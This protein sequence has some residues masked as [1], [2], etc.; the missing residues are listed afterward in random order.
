MRRRRRAKILATLGPSSAS[1][2]RIG[3][4]VDAGA[5]AFRFNFS[6]GTHEQHQA[7]YDAVRAVEEARGR[8]IAVVMDVQGPKLRVGE[9]NDGSVQLRAGQRF[10]LD[11]DGEAGNQD[12]V[13]LPHPEIF[14]T[15]GAGDRLL[16]DDGKIRL[17]VK[18]VASRT[19]DTVVEAGGALSD[20]KGVNLP[21]VVLPLSPLTEKD[22]SDLAFGIDMGVDWVALSFVQR[23]EDVAEA[24][25]LTGGR[26][27]LMA[28]I[29][30]PAAIE[31]LTEIIELSDGIMIARGDLGV[32]LPP[33]DVPSLQ[34]KI[35]RAARDAGKP[36]V[37]ATQMLESMIRAPAPTRAEASDVAT[38]AYDGADAM[39]LSAE[40]AVGDY[41]VEAVAMMDRIL[42]KVERDPLYRTYIDAY[43]A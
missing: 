6:H 30:K 5:D 3:E 16:L 12:R 21:D 28:K 8:P 13:E 36:V 4:L 43:H 10:R 7:R 29:E 31:R 24:R 34:K 17:E 23:P 2:E 9:F 25:R 32:E 39:M 22:R 14:E 35:I 18:E 15:V 20:H 37:V 38:A 40:T 19:I 11:L 26:A 42:A 41:P 27:A 1:P 33:E